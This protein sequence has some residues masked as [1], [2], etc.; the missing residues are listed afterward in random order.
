MTLLLIFYYQLYRNLDELIEFKILKIYVKSTVIFEKIKKEIY[1]F[2][3]LK[4]FYM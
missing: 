2:S 3:F 4:Q 1:R